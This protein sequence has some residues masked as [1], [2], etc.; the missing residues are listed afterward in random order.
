MIILRNAL[1]RKSTTFLDNKGTPRS[2]IRRDEP[3][4][5]K[6]G[7]ATFFNEIL[8]KKFCFWFPE[9]K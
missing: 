5:V 1:P 4:A 7:G 9:G 3:N 8:I 6:R 2:T